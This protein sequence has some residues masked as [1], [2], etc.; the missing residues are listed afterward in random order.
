[1]GWLLV[2]MTLG[3]AWNPQPERVLLEWLAH[4]YVLQIEFHKPLIISSYQLPKWLTT[5]SLVTPRNGFLFSPCLGCIRMP[6]TCVTRPT[7]TRQLTEAKQF[8]KGLNFLL[9]P[10]AENCHTLTSGGSSAELFTHPPQSRA[11]GVGFC[12]LLFANISS[13]LKQQLWLSS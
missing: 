7:G 6:G 13:R 12:P 2:W 8:A 10:E 4:T 1:M 3:T 5:S 11:F 9:I